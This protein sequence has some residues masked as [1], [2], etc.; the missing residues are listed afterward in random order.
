M[1]R[2]VLTYEEDFYT[3]LKTCL[4]QILLISKGYCR[5]GTVMKLIIQARCAGPALPTRFFYPPVLADHRLVRV[6]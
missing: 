4:T 3:I 2:T 5:P 6:N 1:I